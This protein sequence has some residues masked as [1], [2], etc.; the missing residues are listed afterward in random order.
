[1]PIYPESQEFETEKAALVKRIANTLGHSGLAAMREIDARVEVEFAKNNNAETFARAREMALAEARQYNGEEGTLIGLDCKKCKNKG[2]RGIVRE[3]ASAMTLIPCECLK[4]RESIA[5]IEKSGLKGVL[6]IMAL[7]RFDTKTDT[8]KYMKKMAL[9]FLEG[10]EAWM[11]AGGQVGSGKTHICTG[12]C[13]EFLKQGKQVVYMLWKDEAKRLKWAQG[14][15]DYEDQIGKYKFCDILYIDD[16][17]KPP[18]GNVQ[19]MEDI[20]NADIALL[21]EIINSRYASGRR[22]IISSERY[23]DELMQIDEAI[24]S[25]IYQKAKGFTMTIGRDPKKNRRVV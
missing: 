14:D 23:L 19:A 17:Y 7:E 8:A 18:K 15:A 3:D 6:E 4:S 16:L 22:T 24:G 9:E 13:G 1:M 21:F 10:K 2:Y 11:Y 5:N 12:I 20:T 25:R